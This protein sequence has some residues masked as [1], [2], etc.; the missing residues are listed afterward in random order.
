M[1]AAPK[2]GVGLVGIG[3][4]Q[5]TAAE[6]VTAG[7]EVVAEIDVQ[8]MDDGAV[9][10]ALAE[11]V[12]TREVGLV[13]VCVAPRRL[14]V[15]VAIAALEAGCHVLVERPA[16]A[17]LD[18]A[19]RLDAAAGRSPG[20]LWERVTTPFD[21][22]YRRAR[23][24]VAS[25]VIGDVVLV[26]THRSYPWA[27]W[28]DADE[29]RTG[30]LVLQSAGY[31]LDVVRLVAGRAIRSVR[32]ADTTVGEPLGR[33]LR[34]AAVVTAELEGGALA[35]IV[36]DYLNPP[37]GPWG[38]DEVRILGTRGRLSMD[39]AARAIEWV[40]STGEH[41]EVVEDDGPGLAAEIIAA[42]REGRDTDPPADALR[43]ST[44]VLLTA[45]ADHADGSRSVVGEES[46]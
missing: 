13:S 22:P 17:A 45:R 23:E 30:G 4:H 29:R 32:I 35:S 9:V 7:G 20:R 21:Q 28:R 38:R 40:D 41:R 2:V 18:D 15:D 42:V 1:R 36:V 16:A 44:T 26:T 31:G 25:G 14:Q 34:M 46:L 19:M 33:P 11:L 37:G 5:L 24:L 39:A 43:E 6:I 10:R 27:E 12:A 8:A 3:G